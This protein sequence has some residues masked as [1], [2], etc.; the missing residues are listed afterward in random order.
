M[1]IYINRSWIPGFPSGNINL[2]GPDF[3]G[4]Q[5][6]ERP[7]ITISKINHIYSSSLSQFQKCWQPSVYF[8]RDR[9]D[10]FIIKE[11]VPNRANPELCGSPPGGDHLTMNP[12]WQQ[13]SFSLRYIKRF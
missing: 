8:P 5:T 13:V 3:G 11:N 1:K 4:N 10:D 2:E 9:Q 7:E 12:R 6:Q